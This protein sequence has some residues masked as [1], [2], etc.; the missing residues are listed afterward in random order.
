MNLFTI[1]YLSSPF[2]DFTF[3]KENIHT[4]GFDCNSDRIDSI[5]TKD[6]RFSIID[7]QEKLL[8][9]EAMNFYP[10]IGAGQIFMTG[11]Y[12]LSSASSSAIKEQILTDTYDIETADGKRKLNLFRNSV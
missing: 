12:S 8:V 3:A 6:F 1:L 11:S 4:I 7:G 5:V 10:T 2:F 9:L